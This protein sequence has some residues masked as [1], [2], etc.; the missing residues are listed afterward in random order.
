MIKGIKSKRVL[1]KIKKDDI[2]PSLTFATILRV[3]IF[4]ESRFETFTE[5]SIHETHRT[6]QEFF[7]CQS[8]AWKQE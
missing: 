8:F 1:L 6:A 4:R 7:P 5:L 3:Q 2:K